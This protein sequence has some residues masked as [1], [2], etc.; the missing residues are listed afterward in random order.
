MAH[1]LQKKSMQQIVIN[2][3]VIATSLRFV[4]NLVILQGRCS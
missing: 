3:T 4:M 1:Q 2:F